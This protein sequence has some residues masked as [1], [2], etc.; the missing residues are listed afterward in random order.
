MFAP[1][2]TMIS[3][4]VTVWVYYWNYEGEIKGSEFYV[5]LD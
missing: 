2:K 4:T 1:V 3:D 5:I